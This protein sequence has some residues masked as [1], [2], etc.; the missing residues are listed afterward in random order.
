MTPEFLKAWDYLEPAAA[1]WRGHNKQTVWDAIEQ[2]R[3]KLWLLDSGGAVVTTVWTYPSGWK[4]AQA[5]LAGGDLA[6]IVEWAAGPGLHY[7]K[8]NRCN[9]ARMSGRRGFHRLMPEGEYKELGTVVVRD[10]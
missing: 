5:W 6:G 7:A 1:H 9:E 3:A 8:A 2:R 4:S 10:L